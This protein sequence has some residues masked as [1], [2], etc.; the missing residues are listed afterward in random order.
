MRKDLRL[1]LQGAQGTGTV[2]PTAAL[3]ERLLDELC[4]GGRADWDW[5]ALAL[6]VRALSGKALP[7]HREPRA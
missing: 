5:A 3:A 7:E 1:A 6:Q 4:E 2:L